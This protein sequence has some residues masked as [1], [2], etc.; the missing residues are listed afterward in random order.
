MKFTI[1]EKVTLAAIIVMSLAVLSGCAS[2]YVRLTKL[3]ASAQF[4]PFSARG[5]GCMVEIEGLPSGVEM[6]YKDGECELKVNRPLVA[7]PLPIET[8]VK[9]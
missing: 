6:I 1:L 3:D 5:G 7:T 9:L 8:P 4:N 2:N